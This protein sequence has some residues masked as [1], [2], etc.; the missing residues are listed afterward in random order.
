[1][2]VTLCNVLNGERIDV[3]AKLHQT[4][5]EAVVQSSLVG[6][7]EFSVRDEHGNVVDDDP[8]SFHEGA[9]LNIGP[10]GSVAGGDGFWPEGPYLAAV[11]GAAA[12][13][14]KVSLDFVKLWVQERQSRRIRIRKDDWEIEI[15]RA[16]SEKEVEQKIRMVTELMGDER[17]LTIVDGEV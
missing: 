2:P 5:R 15:H 17:R 1:M 10:E 12:A 9:V 14:I 3:D 7:A 8:L 13:G 11:I 6:G 4:V 16:M